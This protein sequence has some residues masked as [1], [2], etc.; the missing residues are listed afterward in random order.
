M[1]IPRFLTWNRQEIN[2]S[3]PKGE[4]NSYALLTP[5]IIK[6]ALCKRHE[7][8]AII[9]LKFIKRLRPNSQ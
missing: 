2:F 9:S 8:E 5:E 6:G 1:S 3:I 7:R 4:W